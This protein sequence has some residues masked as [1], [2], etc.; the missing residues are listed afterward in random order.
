MRCTR[1][2]KL[3]PLHVAGDLAGRRARAVANHLATCEACRRSASAHDASRNLLRAATLPPDFDG[4]FYE[5]IRRSV[6]DQIRRDRTLAPPPSPNIFASLFNARFAYAASLAFVIIAAALALNS[7]SRR[8]TDESAQDK[9]S[10]NVNRADVNLESPAPPQALTAETP[11][12][13][14]DQVAQTPTPSEADAGETRSGG[15]LA[16]GSKSSFPKRRTRRE[17]ARVE[18]RL[19]FA[20]TKLTTSRGKRNS[21][22]PHAAPRIQPNAGELAARDETTTAA[23]SEV[24][25]IE[26]QTSDPNIRIIWL[27]PRPDA[28]AQPLK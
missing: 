3:L 24:S 18:A 1:V 9:V 22:A 8:T 14:R 21:L 4:A 27:S 11:Q 10:A 7:Y 5:E 13:T 2:E 17:S 6:L 23:E 28:V 16:A 19:S 26:I 15:S 12:A 25:R 20:S